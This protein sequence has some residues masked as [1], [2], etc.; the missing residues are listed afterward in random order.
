VQTELRVLVA[1]DHPVYRE[2]IARALDAR[3]ELR[4]VATCSDGREALE[5]LRRHAPDV[6]VLDLGMPGMHGREVIETAA[7]D[8]LPT[9]PLVVSGYVDAA[10]VHAVLGAG[11]SGYLSKSVGAEQ[12]A[13]AAVAVGRGETVLGADVQASLARHLRR[14][15]VDARQLLT[16]RERDVLRLLA[17]GCSA[18]RIARELSIGVTTVKSHLQHVYDKLGVSTGPAAVSQAIHRRLLD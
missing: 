18:A 8:G 11:A 17:D 2:G 7:R 3:P 10:L 13:D 4:L 15:R 16:A 14:E 12:I 1:D 5:E 9:R 6:A